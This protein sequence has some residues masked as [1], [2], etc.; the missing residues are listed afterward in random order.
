MNNIIK[1]ERDLVAKC[2]CGGQLWYILVDKPDFAAITGFQCSFCG[3]VIEI[4][5]T[6]TIENQNQSAGHAMSEPADT[7][8]SEYR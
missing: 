6:S 5:L 8:R 7:N 3:A 4:H 1:I 2:I